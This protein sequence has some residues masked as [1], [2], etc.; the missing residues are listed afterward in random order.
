MTEKKKQSSRCTHRSLAQ[1][2]AVAEWAR[3]ATIQAN[4]QLPTAATSSL[5]AV[6]HVFARLFAANMFEAQ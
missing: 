1:A 6:N 5:T 2:R 4:C 3:A